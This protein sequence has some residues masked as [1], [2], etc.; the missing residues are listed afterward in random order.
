MRHLLLL[1]SVLATT[2]CLR[3][4]QYRCDGDSSCGAGGVCGS[5]R[6]ACAFLDEVLDRR[7]ILVAEHGGGEP[8]L[9]EVLRHAVPH[10]ADA[11]EAD[12]LFV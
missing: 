6:L 4:T 12:A 7:A 2:A 11:D 9:D 8:L 1:V 5:L 3:T 10:H